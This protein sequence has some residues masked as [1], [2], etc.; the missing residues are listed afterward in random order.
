MKNLF[1]SMTSLAG[2]LGLPLNLGGGIEPGDSLDAF[3]QGFANA[4]APFR[5]H[6]IVCDPEAYERLSAGSGGPE[7]FFPRYRAP[8]APEGLL[9]PLPLL[10][11]ALLLPLLLRAALEALL[12]AR[13]DLLHL[14]RQGASPGI[15]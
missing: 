7:G 8:V 6:E 12:H 5:T 15:R 10:A 13:G 2:E 11:L 3:K 9:L 1:A 4:T 14:G